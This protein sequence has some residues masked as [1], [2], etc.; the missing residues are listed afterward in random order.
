MDTETLDRRITFSRDNYILLN[1]KRTATY[2]REGSY[3]NTTD[4]RLGRW[5]LGSDGYGF[6][7]F[8]KGHATRREA[9]EEW[10]VQW[11]PWGR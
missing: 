3:R 4:D 2:V 8:G 5:Y 6:R 10:L 9:A 1:G 11:Y 7:P